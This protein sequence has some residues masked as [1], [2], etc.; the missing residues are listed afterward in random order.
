MAERKSN[1]EAERDARNRN[2]TDPQWESFKDYVKNLAQVPKE[3]LAEE[4]REKKEKR[5]G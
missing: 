4:K 5:A 1:D 3:V 2:D